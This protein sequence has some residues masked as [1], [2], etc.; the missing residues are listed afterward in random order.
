MTETTIRPEPRTTAYSLIRAV[1]LDHAA[2][3][4]RGDE[5]PPPNLGMYNDLT[6]VLERWRAAGTL[7]E[8]SLLLAEWLAVELC[9]YL[10]GRLN[11]DRDRL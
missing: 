1:A 2:R 5:P 9:G 3:D 6:S 11:Q 4:H 7:R 10:Y 8:D